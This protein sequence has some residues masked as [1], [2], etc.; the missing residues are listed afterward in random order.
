MN[1]VID[2]LEQERGKY[3]R[4]EGSFGGVSEMGVFW[5]WPPLLQCDPDKAQEAKAAA[6]REGKSEAHAQE[7]ADEAKRTPAEKA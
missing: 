2:T 4:I 7:A 3:S 1:L 5:D 6:L